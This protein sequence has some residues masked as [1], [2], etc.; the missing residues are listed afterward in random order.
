VHLGVI[1]P[2]GQ[3]TFQDNIIDSL[4]HLGHRV[5]L[6]G[7]TYVGGGRLVGRVAE[8]ALGAL[9]ELEDRYHHRLVHTVLARGC[10]AVINN[11]G[12][13]SPNAVAASGDSSGRAVHNVSK[14]SSSIRLSVNVFSSCTPTL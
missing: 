6:L 12:N 14:K 5:S 8:L 4:A 10:D 9:P 2:T 3:D 11:R 13:L 7:D 1:G